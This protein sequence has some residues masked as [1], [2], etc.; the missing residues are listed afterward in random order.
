MTKKVRGKEEV[1]LPEEV[2]FIREAT[3]IKKKE[4][5]PHL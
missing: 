4:K 2:K 3:L 5:N 1:K